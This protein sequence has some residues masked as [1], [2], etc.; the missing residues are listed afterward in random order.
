M[1]VITEDNVD[2]HVREIVSQLVEHGFEAYVVGG[3]VRDIAL[4]I[5][6]KDYDIATSATPRQIK[7]V[8]GRKARVIGRR[9]RLV[10]VYYGQ[11]YYEVSTFRREPTAEERSTRPDDD[12][13]II[14]QDNVYGSLDEDVYR[15]DFT[16]NALYA[17]P[18]KHDGIIDKVGGLTDIENKIV[19]TINEADIRIAEDPVRI[20]RA[21]KMVAKY[22]FQ[23]ESELQEAVDRRKADIRKSSPSRLFEELL[24][25]YSGSDSEKTLQVFHDFGVLQYFLPELD[26]LWE[27]ETGVVVRNL[28]SERDRRRAEG[29]YSNSRVLALITTAFP[30]VAEEMGTPAIED[31]SAYQPELTSRVAS[32]I[33]GLFA[34]LPVPKRL[35]AR[36]RDAVLLLPRF[37]THDHQSRLLH[38][39]EY[40]YAR[41]LLA[42]LT[43]VMGWDESIISEWPETGRWRPPARNAGKKRRNR[44]PAANRQ[45]HEADKQNMGRE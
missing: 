5:S 30:V 35:T 12:G 22:D 40:R 21:L 7:R 34:P 1:F 14:W 2:A 39:P 4:G 10:H 24:K 41:E 32:V 11:K 29:W 27:T 3:A 15:R 37:T 19:R 17:N 45:Q 26:K 42:L 20:I 36:A 9:F 6:P 44:H 38:H 28:L 13:T 16:V 31:M 18:L 25:I 23:L 8:F 43:K 33:R